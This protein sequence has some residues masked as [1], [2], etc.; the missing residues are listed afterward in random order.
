MK[1]REIYVA[2][3]KHMW[4][5]EIWRIRRKNERNGSD[6]NAYGLDS[7]YFKSLRF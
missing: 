5:C 3:M 4:V 7:Y 1:M 6:I 2:T